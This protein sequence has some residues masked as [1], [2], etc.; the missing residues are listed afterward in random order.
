MRIPFDALIR[1][2]NSPLA[3]FTGK[4]EATGESRVIWPPA[5]CSILADV[6]ARNL[7]RTGTNFENMSVVSVTVKTGRT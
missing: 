6:K 2:V 4:R 3:M 1:G 5:S 7:T